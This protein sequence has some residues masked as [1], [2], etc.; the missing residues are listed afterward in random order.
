[1]F[2]QIFH[3]SVKPSCFLGINKKEELE[4]KCKL[5]EERLVRADKL[6][7]GL[8]DEKIRWH[9]TVTSLDHMIANI[10]GDVMVSAGFVAYLGAFTVRFDSVLSSIGAMCYSSKFAIYK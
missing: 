7:N 4:T 9:D 6:I 1:M 10:I 2:E 8:A 5:C 3:Q